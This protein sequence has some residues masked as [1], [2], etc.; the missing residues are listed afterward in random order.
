MSAP[1]VAARGPGRGVRRALLPVGDRPVG[2]SFGAVAVLVARDDHF[3]LH[4][5][6]PGHPERP[7]R[8]VAVERGLEQAGLAE[9]LV[10]F[11]PEA[12][13]PEDLSR[14]HSPRLLASLRCLADLGGGDVDPDTR[15]GAESFEV[16]VLAAG[17]GPDAVRRLRRG[18]AD[19][20]FLALRPPGHHATA[21]A[22][23]GFCL[24]NN[25][26]VTAGAILAEAPGE[27]VA[28]VDYDAHH[29]N[30]TQD[31]FY[32]DPRVLYISFHQWPLYPGSGRISEWG[33]GEG[34]GTTCNVPFPSRTTG[35]AYRRALDEIVEPA[36]A[37]FRP[38]WLLLSAGFD[39]HRDDPLTDLGLTAG[40]FYDL[41]SHLRRLVP[42]GRLVA[43]LEGGYDLEALAH[44]A[45]AAV[46]ALA[47][48]SYRPEPASGAG[49]GADVIAEVRR[50]HPLLAA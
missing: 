24:V 48:A 35:D 4:V 22:A 19:T 5:T 11:R 14:T 49:P 26:A 41:T 1:G 50:R 39:A 6:G 16:A 45:G 27:R 17:A 7:A 31:I 40:D 20:A 28:I 30:G 3:G 15:V 12:A 46:A 2:T 32:R 38:D 33:E 10:F 9:A 34:V 25:V 21:D 29:G 37:Q 44:S 13:R 8:L 43:F 47:G 42:P 23:M 18:E 36:F